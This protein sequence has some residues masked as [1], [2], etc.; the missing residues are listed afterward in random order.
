MNKSNLR[1]LLALGNQT[2]VAVKEKDQIKVYTKQ[3]TTSPN[4]SVKKLS[5][6]ITR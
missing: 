1:F 6:L 5:T 4:V 3:H 2:V